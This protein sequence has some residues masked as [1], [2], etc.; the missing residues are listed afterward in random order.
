MAVLA[1]DTSAA[2]AVALL[3][4]LGT[5]LAARRVVEQRRQKQGETAALLSQ[6]EA[7]L[8]HADI[9]IALARDGRFELVSRQYCEVFGFRAA[10]L[11]GQPTSIIHIS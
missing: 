7:V 2:V 5:Q 4:N 3:D 8:D 9:G 10:D 6:L 1:L 11:V